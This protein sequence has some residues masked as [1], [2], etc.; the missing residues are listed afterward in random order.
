MM[1]MGNILKRVLIDEF[2]LSENVND[3]ENYTQELTNGIVR[4]ENIQQNKGNHQENEE[5]A[6]R[7]RRNPCLFFSDRNQYLEFI[8]ISKV[9]YPE[10]PSGLGRWLSG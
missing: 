7:T 3:R 10:N 9:Q 6:Y 5:K 4:I 1:T 2:L 8:K